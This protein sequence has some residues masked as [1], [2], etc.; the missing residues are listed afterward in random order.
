MQT[1]TITVSV[2]K[3]LLPVDIERQVR[4]RWI[5]IKAMGLSYD[6]LVIRY[7]KYKHKASDALM[8]N[9]G[10]HTRLLILR[11]AYAREAERVKGL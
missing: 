7:Q 3:E 9:T 4:L 10:A 8:E 6:E 11:E 5:E 2:L 1:A